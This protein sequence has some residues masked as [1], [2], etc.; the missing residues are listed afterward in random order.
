MTCTA[1]TAASTCAACCGCGK[2]CT[3][4]QRHYQQPCAQV[5]A[6]CSAN[7]DPRNS[8]RRSPHDKSSAHRIPVPVCRCQRETDSIIQNT[9]ILPR[10]T[11]RRQLQPL[12]PFMSFWDT[13][14]TCSALCTCTTLTKTRMTITLGLAARVLLP[15]RALTR[16]R[17]HLAISNKNTV[18]VLATP[19]GT[20]TACGVG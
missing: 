7:T 2:S 12:L 1:R 9:T 18:L 11:R 16:M 5:D 8:Q 10:F 13:K 4:A 3:A 19:G 15:A 6:C 17:G 14:V 20:S